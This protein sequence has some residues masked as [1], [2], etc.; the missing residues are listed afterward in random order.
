MEERMTRIIAIASGKGGVGK[1]F[2]SLQLSGAIAA[3]GK[4]VV[5]F[6]GDLGLGNIHV[7]LGLKPLYDLSAVVAGQKTLPEILLDGPGG[8][9]ILPGASGVRQLA[10]LGTA[11]LA[12]V[13]QGFTDI[14]PTPDVMIIDAG[15]GIG[16]HV[17]SLVRLSDRLIVVVRDEAASLA[18]GYALI[19]VMHQDFGYEA[20]DVV[21]ND[22]ETLSRGNAI[23]T[24][25]NDVATRFL[26]IPLRH[27]GTILHDQAVIETARR[28]TLL[29]LHAPQSGATAAVRA[30]ATD[31]I[32]HI[33]SDNGPLYL[34]DRLTKTRGAQ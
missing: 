22:V 10:E 15:A 34:V 29:G 16:D 18:D 21:I 1:T 17:T 11:D 30:I 28:K 32:Q 5:L 7:V 2:L 12:R 27:V 31:V 4:R 20:F 26:G 24:K 14:V 6:D 25:I 9:K 13:L 33:S 23:F 3:T 8:I 19:K